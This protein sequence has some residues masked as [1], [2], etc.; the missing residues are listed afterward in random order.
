[1]VQW[2][3]LKGHWSIATPCSRSCNPGRVVGS[4]VRSLIPWSDSIWPS[5]ENADFDVAALGP[6]A[7][8]ASDPPSVKWLPCG[9]N[10]VLT[11]CEAL[12]LQ[13]R[14][15]KPPITDCRAARCVH[16]SSGSLRYLRMASLSILSPRLDTILISNCQVAILAGLAYLYLFFDAVV[17]VQCLSEPGYEMSYRRT[18]IQLALPMGGVKLEG[19]GNSLT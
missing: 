7:E 17:G 1:M 11:F 15:F 10:E 2:R 19:R 16:G 13:A 9:S 18:I 3:K 4:V 6:S 14:R 12:S 8:Q 5:L